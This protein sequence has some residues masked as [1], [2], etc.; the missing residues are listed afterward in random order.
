MIWFDLK[1]CK[2]EYVVFKNVE[3][4]GIACK[5]VYSGLKLECEKYIKENN[6]KLGKINARKIEF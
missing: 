4:H 2:Q 1:R 6:I 5:K 3:N